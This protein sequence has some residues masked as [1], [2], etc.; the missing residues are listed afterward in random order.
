MSDSGHE[1][2]REVPSAS[3][4]MKLLDTLQTAVSATDKAA[5]PLLKKAKA[6]DESLDLSSGLSLLLVR[7]HLLLSGLHH[8]IVL[9][10]LRL[11]T[12]RQT[13]PDASSSAALASAFAA[14]RTRP[15]DAVWEDE[16]AGELALCHEVMD[17]VRGM[18]S[19]LEYQV[20]KLVGL[21][22]A[23]NK[24]QDEV[25][26]DPLSFRPNPSAMVTAARTEKKV[27]AAAKTD[28]DEVY[29]PPR[30]AAMPYNEPGR[31]RARERRAPALLSEFAQTMDGAPT[32]QTTSGLSTRPVLAGAHSN[33]VSAK[34]AAELKRL[35]TWE[36]DNM[37]RLV[38]TKREAK[39]RRDDEEALALGFGVGGAGRSRRQ[40]GLEAE[41]EG[42]LG[43]RGSKGV[44][45]STGVQALGMRE[46]ITGRAKRA[47]E[48]AAPRRGLK[49]SRFEKD[50]KR[51]RRAIGLPTK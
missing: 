41:L 13:Q 40:N 5:R 27:A 33:S 35:A 4:I 28:D 32:V 23:A 15:E 45:D 11:S 47:A 12:L 10:G 17:K 8:L 29:R 42:V 9:V 14:G 46:G 22:E 3:E 20:K 6:G 16:L 24:P 2:E 51:K 43:E 30:V 31:E 50:V 1:S 26:E 39:R 48:D 7:P 34:R 25:E 37:T 18:E 21:A 19:K 49:K 36:E 38:T 44:W